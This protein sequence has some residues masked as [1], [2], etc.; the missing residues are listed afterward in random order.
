MF[1]QPEIKVTLPGINK[2][3]CI[4]ACK[5]NNQQRCCS[6]DNTAIDAHA[7]AYILFSFSFSFVFQLNPYHSMSHC[8]NITSQSMQYSQ[9]KNA[10]H[11][12]RACG[13]NMDV[14]KTH[15]GNA[16]CLTSVHVQCM[17]KLVSGLAWC[18]A[19]C[20][21]AQQLESTIAHSHAWRVV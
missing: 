3:I 4:Q 17:Q 7:C 8:M 21:E 2:V 6:V 15:Q 18:I 1:T 14:A 16:C 10:T 9:C 11:Y 12:K 13:A 20:G 5:P 19:A